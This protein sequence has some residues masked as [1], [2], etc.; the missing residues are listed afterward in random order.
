MRILLSS[1]PF[2]PDV[3]GIETISLLLA[4]QWSALGHD[5]IVVTNTA[6]ETE[7][8]FPFEVVRRPDFRTLRR[9]I[10]RSDLFFQNN[11]SLQFLW[12]WLGTRKPLFIAHQTW[13]YSDTRAEAL[14]SALKRLF[15][16]RATSISISNAIAAAIAPGSIVVPNAYDD[17]VFRP[18]PGTPRNRDLVFVG[19]LVEDK[20]ADVLL[21]ALYSLKKRGLTPDLTLIGAGPQEL[22]LRELC[23]QL[24]L[25]NQVEFAGIL[26]GEALAR[27][28]GAHRI[29]V[30]PSTWPEPFGIVAL[31]GIACGCAIVAS[32]GGGLPDAVG[33]CGVLFQN[34]EGDD[35]AGV[36]APLLGDSALLKPLLDAAPAHLEK[37]RGEAVA[38]AYL[39]VFER[40]K[41]GSIRSQ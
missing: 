19:R 7:E 27:R 39:Q 35:L 23:A 26:R 36:L 1:Y 30:V 32:N 22:P 10:R 33:E 3:G 8:K 14:R 12:A 6:E 11:V 25:E 37:H 13:L 15:I 28:I 24:G 5:V 4:R 17:A 41:G 18:Y 38:R 34:G 29:L 9:L 40:A 20:G 31:E 21:R 2:T 16:R